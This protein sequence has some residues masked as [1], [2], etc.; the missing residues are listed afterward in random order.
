MSSRGEPV[1]L[2]VS[3]QGKNALK[4]EAARL[5]KLASDNPSTSPADLARPLLAADT[6]FADRAVVV[7]DSRTDMISGLQALARADEVTN[8]VTG[9]ARPTGGIVFVFPGQ[10]PQWA[11]MG[12]NLLDSNAAF[13]RQLNE[14]AKA[15]LPYTGWSAVDVI[16]AAD[17]RLLRRVDIVQPTLWAIMTSL[18]AAWE[19]AG[20]RPDAV[21]GHSQGEI[22]A[23][24]VAGALSLGDAARTIVVRSRALAKLG[25]RG[26][27]AAIPLPADT[28]AEDIARFNDQISIAAI[29][30]PAATVVSGKLAAINELVLSYLTAGVEARRIAVK[31]ASHSADVGAILDN[32]V[33]GLSH[34]RPTAAPIAFCSTVTGDVIADT[35]TLDASYWY[36]NLR[37]TVRFSEAIGQLHKRGYKVFLEISTHPVLTAAIQDSV[38]DGV[39]G[40]TLR[41]HGDSQR[42]LLMSAGELFVQGIPV[43]WQSLL[44]C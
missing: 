21:V 14:C 6:I 18:A 29:N 43:T 12:L 42:Q 20:I 13:T 16:R 17:L 34:I 11:G 39:I 8:V 5:C 38:Q 41:R 7:A 33:Y 9:T 19:A 25:E 28:V 40:A 1:A 4:A 27:M 10:G 37:D 2:V 31:H 30:A 36:R 26:A 32:I 15:L 3:A 44:T 35:S 23:A 22:A 24:Y